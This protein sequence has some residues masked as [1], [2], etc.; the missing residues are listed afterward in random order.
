M[1]TLHKLYAASVNM[2]GRSLP[3]LT[4]D[5]VAQ[6]ITEGALLFIHRSRV[7]NATAWAPIHPGGV[8]AIL[9]FVGRDATDE[10]E[11]YH[12][13][14]AL[15]RMEKYVVGVVQM[16]EELGW[17]ALTPPIALG[18]VRHSDAVKG[19]WTREGSVRLAEAVLKGDEAPVIITLSPEQ[20]EPPPSELDRRKE[21]LRSN[22]YHHLKERIVEAGLFNRP[23][24]LA[25]YGSDI[26]R[27]TLLG[28]LGFGFYF[29]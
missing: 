3:I 14:E 25:G 1:L 13:P 16:D 4:R 9:H 2:L 12:S 7:I 6:R 22:A 10:F 29:M 11:A 17:Q 28:S 27:Y 23:G 26:L 15:K 21:R 19:H 8:L 20:L 18:L 5:E 24:P